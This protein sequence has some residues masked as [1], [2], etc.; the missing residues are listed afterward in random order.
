VD[1]VVAH[2][3]AL[4]LLDDAQ[5]VVPSTSS[6]MMALSPASVVSAWRSS[7]QS[8]AIGTGSLPSP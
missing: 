6:L 3:V 7:R 4:E 5:L 1:D 2:R 8:T